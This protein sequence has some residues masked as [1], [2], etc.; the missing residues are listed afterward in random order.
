MILKSVKYNQYYGQDKEWQLVNFEIPRICLLVGKNASG[1]SRTLNVLDGLAN[2]ISGYKKFNYI[3]G[4]YQ[5]LYDLNQK[6]IIYNLIYEDRQII[7]ESL[8]VD[9]DS[10]LDRGSDGSGKVYFTQEDKM[11]DFQTPTNQLACVARKDS[12]QHPFFE[13]IYNWGMSTYKYTFGGQLGKNAYLMNISEQLILREIDQKHTEEVFKIFINGTLKYPDVFKKRVIKDF[14][15]VGYDITDVR[16]Y[17]IDS[18][19]FQNSNPLGIAVQESRLKTWTNQLDM[20]QG[21]FRALSLIIQLNYSFLE[22]KSCCLLI[23]DIGEGLDFE[24]STNL[25]GLLI[26]HIKRNK[27]VQVIMTTN[28]QYVMNQIPLEY[29]SVVHCE[30][31]ISRI[32]NYLNSKKLFESFKFTGLN[33]FDFFSSDYFLKTK[34]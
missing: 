7:K 1:K 19:V 24:R 20:S 15:S 27:S 33:N 28:D 17:T 34:E 22:K 21:M 5:V 9:G 16:M 6:E 10:V 12:I 30:N 14:N 8:T 26:K 2:L 29:W 18:L 4:N 31:Y 3:S 25:I 23:D 13:D 32:Y 11:L